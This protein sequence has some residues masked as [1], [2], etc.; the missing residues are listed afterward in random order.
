M[1]NS[2]K[3]TH[4]IPGYILFDVSIKT[5]SLCM[6]IKLVNEIKQLN[7]SQKQ[8]LCDS[9]P[10]VTASLLRIDSSS[11]MIISPTNDNIKHE[12]MINLQIISNGSH[13][14]LN[15]LDSNSSNNSN[16]STNDSPIIDHQS[17]I[18][19][20]AF[21]LVGRELQIND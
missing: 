1:F 10:K 14:S 2:L 16:N 8:C 9:I 7:K 20:W 4:I 6:L 19:K 11:N 3:P 12:D 13:E 17:G 15:T 5:I 18:S 21:W